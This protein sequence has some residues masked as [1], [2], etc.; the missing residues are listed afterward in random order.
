VQLSRRAVARVRSGHPWIFRSDLPDQTTPR[1][2]VVQLLDDKGRFLASALS[3]SSSQIALRVISRDPVEDEQAVSL[4]AERLRTAIAYRQQ[5]Y[6]KR[7]AFR[8]AFSEADTLPGFIAD[9]YHDVITVQVLT[10]FMDR[11]DVRASLLD[12][13]GSAFPGCSM[14][15]RVDARVRQLEDLPA[16]ESRVLVGENTATR[17]ELNGL[18]F[19]FDALAGQKTGAF[20]DQQENYARAEE[21]AFGECL[22]VFTYHGGFALHLARKC[23]RVTAVDASRAALE[24]AEANE[25]ANRDKLAGDEIEWIEADAFELLKDFSHP[26]Q[27]RRFD[28]IVL[29]PPA[30]AKSKRAVEGALRGYKEINLRALKMLRPGGILITNSCSFHV[31]PTEF[32][33]A[34]AAAA[35][36]A[37]RSVKILERRA[38]AIDH[39][40]VPT[41]PESD[42]LKCF[43]CHVQ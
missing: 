39:P 16:A 21:Y 3:S 4:V 24:T 10:Q 9:K 2:T 41:I 30:F 40:V 12:V 18:S 17:F 19:G 31:S 20:L 6:A 42:Y 35:A 28:T 25:Q 36:D 37:G 7:D 23:T 13:L 11:E 29:D 27:G 1:A 38:A 14:V 26:Q 15:E 8:V 43:I 32:Q 22:D 5:R 34:L 33:Q